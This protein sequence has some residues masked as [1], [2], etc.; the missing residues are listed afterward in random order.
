[1]ANI[2]L[3]TLVLY[4]CSSDKIHKICVS[5]CTYIPYNIVKDLIKQIIHQPEQIAFADDLVILLASVAIA[6][7]LFRVSR[8]TS[9]Q[10]FVQK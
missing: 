5:L 1:M 4:L 3:R 2:T 9:L 8:K 6:F 10:V 7:Q